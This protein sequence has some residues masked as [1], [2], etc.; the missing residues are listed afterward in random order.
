MLET[1]ARFTNDLYIKTSFDPSDGTCV[2]TVEIIT[3]GVTQT[4]T[5]AVTWDE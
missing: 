4:L 5:G 3:E 2:V 1:G